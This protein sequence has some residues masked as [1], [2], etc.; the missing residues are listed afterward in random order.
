MRRWIIDIKLVVID[1]KYF[2]GDIVTIIDE[3]DKKIEVIN[4]KKRLQDIIEI[5]NKYYHVV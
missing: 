5:D 1:L 2:K 4:N 3:N